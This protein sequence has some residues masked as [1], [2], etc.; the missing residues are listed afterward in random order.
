MTN[1]RS[2]RSLEGASPF[3]PCFGLRGVVG[4]DGR[5]LTSYCR[6]LRSLEGA[7][8][9]NPCSGLS[10]PT[11]PASLRAQDV[12]RF[13]ARYALPALTCAALAACNNTVPFSG[14][15]DTPGPVAVLQEGGPFAGPVAYAADAHGG[16]IRVLDVQRG[17]Y[18][19]ETP[20]ALFLRGA[21]LGTGEDR[22][23]AGL[24]PRVTSEGGV[25]VLAIDRRYDQLLRVPH[26]LGVDAAG[27]PILPEPTITSLRFTDAD[28]SGDD[29]ALASLSVRAG[30]ASSETWTLTWHDD[31]WV[32][33]GSRSGPQSLIARPGR[34]YSTR[35]GSLNFTAAGRATDGDSIEIVVDSG[36]QETQLG[37]HPLT[38]ALSP[39]G[40]TLAIVI[41]NETDRAGETQLV[42]LDAATATPT[43]TIDLGPSTSLNALV[44]W[45]DTL[46][47]GDGAAPVLWEIPATGEPV[48]HALVE[49]VLDLEVTSAEDGARQRLFAA[50][51][52]GRRVWMYDLTTWA[53][54]DINVATPE[55]DGMWFTSPV[56]GLAGSSL[57]WNRPWV[58][59]QEEPVSGLAVAVSLQAGRLVWMQEEDGCLV[60]DAL[61]PRTSAEQSSQV[62]RDYVASFELSPPYSASLQP[63]E[64]PSHNVNVNPCAGLAWSE[65]WQLRY[66]EP[67][68]VWRA[69]GAISGDQAK[70]VQ[71]DSRYLS[72]RAQLSLL[73][74]AGERPTL[75]N[76]T[77][78]FEILDG[79][80]A[81]DG[82]EDGDPDQEV[83]FDLPSD[84]VTAIIE[85][86]GQQV[87]V[88]VVAAQ[89]SDIVVRID[90]RDGSIDRVWD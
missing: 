82:E 7:G 5:S 38:M 12:P 50:S 89:A 54:I 86:E 81:V 52:D 1:C 9:F 24:A 4:A 69:R 88:V 62:A 70:V 83:A 10:A 33:R 19:T 6:S 51:A 25:E 66:D 42:W 31:G 3:N 29:P 34:P 36:L 59:E 87:P 44:W 18:L 20:Y 65:Q 35:E 16:R 68:Q 90:P 53:P 61:G 57:A 22:L 8:P 76:A 14:T 40:A 17:T 2:L 78:T 80:L 46:L 41:T 47:A 84:P 73:V 15:L 71:E 55:L 67:A 27:S 72:D 77:I 26:V 21:G 23:L 45:G 28:S 32:V 79:V 63:T 48:S 13:F 60:P 39:D 74:R 75:D 49:P 64:D 30:H 56:R 37:G 58:Q 43:R 11:L 85:I